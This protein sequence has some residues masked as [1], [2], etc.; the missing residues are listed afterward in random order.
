MSRIAKLNYAL[1]VY[2]FPAFIYFIHWRNNR[3]FTPD[4]DYNIIKKKIKK[5]FNINE[6]FD[7]VSHTGYD[8][9]MTAL[10]MAIVLNN[11]YL[12]SILL[13]NRANVNQ[14]C[15]YEGYEYTPLALACEYG[16]DETMI[17][18]IL[19][20]EPTI[21]IDNGRDILSPLYLCQK[22]DEYYYHI[23][24]CELFLHGLK[25]SSDYMFDNSRQ[26]NYKISILWLRNFYTYF[27]IMPKDI[28]TII[29][30]FITLDGI[31]IN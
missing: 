31:H 7:Y 4:L 17:F 3:F 12:V 16:E 21:N 10:T 5:G 13:S 28:F 20:Y 18:D 9:T 23:C 27:T 26:D 1:A 2:S 24:I 14:T 25:L 8:N 6:E 22:G 19:S 30:K 11:E 29:L 15:Y